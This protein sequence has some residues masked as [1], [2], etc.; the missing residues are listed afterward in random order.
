VKR[1]PRIDIA[2]NVCTI[3]NRIREVKDHHDHPEKAGCPVRA[4]LDPVV[5]GSAPL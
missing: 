1:K 3:E 4:C 5:R 2:A